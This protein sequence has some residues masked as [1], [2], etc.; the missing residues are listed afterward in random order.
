MQK[1]VYCWPDK[2]DFK[3]SIRFTFLITNNVMKYARADELSRLDPS[4][5]KATMGISVKVLNQPNT[6]DEQEV[7]A[8]DA[9]DCRSPIIEYLKS[10]VIETDSKS[11]KLRIRAAKYIFID[12]ILYKNLSAFPIFDVWHQMKPNTS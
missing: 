7:M 2:E 1:Q 6:A 5:P 9:P 4:D 3:Y 10:L 8:I 11:A 12:D